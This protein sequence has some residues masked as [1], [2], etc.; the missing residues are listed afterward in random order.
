MCG[1]TQPHLGV[2]KPG[3]GMNTWKRPFIA[4]KRKAWKTGKGTR[5]SYDAAK[6]N[7]RHAV[8]H[9]HQDGLREY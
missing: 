6:H 7:A 1:T 2:V 5:A 8:Q 3:G 9:A 4:A